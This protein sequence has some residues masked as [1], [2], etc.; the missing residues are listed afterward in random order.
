MYVRRGTDYEYI[1]KIF[2][3]DKWKKNPTILLNYRL[4]DKGFLA[5]T[6]NKSGGFSGEVMLYYKTPT[7]GKVAYIAN[8][9]KYSTEKETLFINGT[10]AIIKEIRTEVLE[11]RIRYNIFL[12]ME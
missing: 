10:A 8:I 5:T 4:T 1:N 3:S 9:S 2:D 6:P 12:D 7:K 11:G